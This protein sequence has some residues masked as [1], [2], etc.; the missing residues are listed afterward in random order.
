M[1]QLSPEYEAQAETIFSPFTGDPSY[2]AYGGVEPEEEA[3][4]DS[5]AP[6]VERFREMHR[7]AFTV[8]VVL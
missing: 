6:P 1:P 2:M 8:K 4:P 5:D 3:D 7:L